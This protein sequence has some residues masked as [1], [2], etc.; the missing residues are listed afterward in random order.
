[1]RMPT[2]MYQELNAMECL[3]VIRSTAVTRAAFTDGA[4]PFLAP[5]G[6][7]SLLLLYTAILVRL[8]A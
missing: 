3:E 1:M 7:I 5:I 2:L 8:T 4:R 6:S